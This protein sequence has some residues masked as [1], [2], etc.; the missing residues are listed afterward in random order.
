[1]KLN[2]CL[3]EATSHDSV[4]LLVMELG[5]QDSST[6]LVQ[7]HMKRITEGKQQICHMRHV[8]PIDLLFSCFVLKVEL[9][10]PWELNGNSCAVCRI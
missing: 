10:F 3:V 1:M 5:F 7:V 8:N 2:I 4:R 9:D 6:F